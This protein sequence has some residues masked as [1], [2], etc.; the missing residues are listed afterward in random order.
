MLKFLYFHNTSAGTD[1]RDA[2]ALPVT[3][4]RKMEIASIGASDTLHLEFQ[5]VQDGIGANITVTLTLTHDKGREVKEAIANA[6][7][8]SSSPLIVVADELNNQFI[9]PDVTAVDSMTLA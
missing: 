3:L 6:I 5:D 2:V 9:H 1:G 7:R 4:L 8:K